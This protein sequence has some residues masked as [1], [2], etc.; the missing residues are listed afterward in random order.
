MDELA[1]NMIRG[2]SSQGSINDQSTNIEKSEKTVINVYSGLESDA[3]EVLA[4]IDK[5]VSIKDLYDG[6]VEK[7]K[8]GYSIRVTKKS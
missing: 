2:A 4:I 7:D 6:K 3:S 1:K 5:L 8:D